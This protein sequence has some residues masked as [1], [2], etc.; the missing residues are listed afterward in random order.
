MTRERDV[1]KYLKDGVE[2]LGGTCTKWTGEAGVPD[3]IVFLPLRLPL[4]FI[5]TKRPGEIV[6]RSLQVFWKG[7]LIGNGQ[8][9]A[10]LSTKAEVDAWLAKRQQELHRVKH[11]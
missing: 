2:D 8:N 3:R 7:F 9:Y 10:E 6:E 4:W 1:E 5:E 11:G